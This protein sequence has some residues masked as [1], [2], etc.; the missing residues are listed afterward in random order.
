MTQPSIKFSDLLADHAKALDRFNEATQA[1]QAAHSRE[2]S[3]L[4]LLNAAQHAIDR[5]MDE[6]RKHAP[7]QSDWKREPRCKP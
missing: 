2:T 6:L 3:A 1:L 7:P 4:N 5:A